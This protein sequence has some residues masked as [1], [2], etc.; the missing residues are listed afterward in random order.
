MRFGVDVEVELVAF[1][2]PGG[3]RPVFGAIGHYDRNH[4]I[5]RV[6]IGFHGR[7]FGACACVS[8]AVV[9]GFGPLYNASSPL[10]Q[11][12]MLPNS[13]GCGFASAGAGSYLGRQ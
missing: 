4:M 10:K 12:R 7:S 9:T 6:N 11:G 2:A 1:L 8:M 3:T 13:C 5:I